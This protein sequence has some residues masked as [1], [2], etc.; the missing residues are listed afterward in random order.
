[1]LALGPHLGNYE[2][3]LKKGWIVERS[4]DDMSMKMEGKSGKLAQI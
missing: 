4:V 1:M 3:M 2:P